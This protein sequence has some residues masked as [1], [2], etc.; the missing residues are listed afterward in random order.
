MDAYL[1]RVA[2]PEDAPEVETLL[3]TSYPVLMADAYDEGVLAPVL[4]LITKANMALLTSK[5]FYVAETRDGSLIGCGGWTLETP[6]GTDGVAG[7]H[8]H[9]RHFATHPD[10]TR[11]GV[12]RAIYRQWEAAARSARVAALEVCSSLNGEPFYAAQG[13][14]RIKSIAVAIGPDSF[15]SVLMRRAI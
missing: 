3:E 14:E 12:G 15:P 4:S 8:G 6:P 2:I 7:D 13:F 5:T 11:R 1:T 9:L 10:W